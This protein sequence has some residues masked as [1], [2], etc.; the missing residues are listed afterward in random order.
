MSECAGKA[1]VLI[2]EDEADIRAQVSAILEDDYQVVEADGHDS[3]IAKARSAGPK[4]IVLDVCMPGKDGF[5]V[6]RTLSEDDALKTI[7]VIMLTGVA[8]ATG[9]RFSAE[10]MGQYFGR[11]PSTYLEKPVNPNALLEAVKKASGG[12]CCCCS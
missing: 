4:V 1:T 3:G 11:E 2:I 5:E 9:L 10:E 12:G 8:D 7:P 6:F